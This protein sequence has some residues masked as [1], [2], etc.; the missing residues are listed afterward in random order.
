MISG[1]RFSQPSRRVGPGIL[2]V[3]VVALSGLR[4]VGGAG[5]AEATGTWSGTGSMASGRS[6]FTLTTLKS[7][8]VLAAGGLASSNANSAVA[9]TELFDP[10]AGTWSAT[11]GGLTTARHFHKLRRADGRSAPAA[12]PPVRPA[13]RPLR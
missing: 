3:A 4:G 2:L 13:L 8:L 7:G 1:V 9:A 5:R 6:F 10:S 11:T 12:I